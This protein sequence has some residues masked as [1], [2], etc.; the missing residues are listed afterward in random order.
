MRGIHRR[1]RILANAATCQV[2]ID[3][4]LGLPTLA[5]VLAVLD[6]SL[7]LPGAVPVSMFA[8][9]AHN[10]RAGRRVNINNILTPTER[11]CSPSRASWTAA[12]RCGTIGLSCIHSRRCTADD[13]KP[14]VRRSTM[15]T[16]AK[17]LFRPEA[18]RPKLSAFTV[19]RPPRRP[20]SSSAHWVQVARHEEGRGDEGNGTAGR[21]HRRRVRRRSRLHR[22]GRGGGAVTPSSAK[23][24][25]RWT[26]SSPTPPWVGFRP[27]TTERNTS[28]PWKARGRATP[29]TG[30]SPAASCPPSIRRSA[31]PSTWNATGIWSPTC[32]KSGLYHKGHDQF[33]FERFE[34][35]ALA[36]D[37]AAFRRFVFLLAA[38]RMVPRDRP[39]SPRRPD[40]RI[41]AHRPGTDARLLPRLR[42]PAPARRFTACA[43]ATPPCRRPAC[44]PPRKPSSTA[45]CSSPFARTAACCRRSPSPGRIA[46]PTPTTRGRSGTTSGCSGAVDEGNPATEH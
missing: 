30:P 6:G 37:D 11:G 1:T 28:P 39:L 16:A 32:T 42:R 13:D 31:T 34:T 23:R 21:L 46:T 10:T 44:W 18:L 4:V 29:S 27:P 26:A 24:P 8:K 45:C 43:S 7:S 40:G 20:G 38:E 33:T 15:P 14:R 17:P 9:S 35:A 25:S 19:P 12:N 5:D 41:P 36:D 3:G 22:P 2:K